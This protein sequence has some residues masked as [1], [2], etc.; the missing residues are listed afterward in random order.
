MIKR[1]CPSNFGLLIYE[2]RLL[3]NERRK[4]NHQ[5]TMLDSIM[6]LELTLARPSFPTTTRFT[7]VP[8]VEVED[9]KEDSRR[10]LEPFA[11]LEVTVIPDHL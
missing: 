3:W 9:K 8:G 1:P 11:V 2:V 6:F 4:K 10:A 7:T 5:T